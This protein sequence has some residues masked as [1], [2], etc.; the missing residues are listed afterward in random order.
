VGPGCS[1][2]PAGLRY[3]PVPGINLDS[4]WQARVGV[5][6]RQLAGLD[7]DAAFEVALDCARRES[8]LWLQRLDQRF[9]ERPEFA[10]F[11]GRVRSGPELD[12]TVPYNDPAILAYDFISAG[13]Y[14]PR[15]SQDS[16]RWFHRFLVEPGSAA[17]GHRGWLRVLDR[18]GRQLLAFALPYGRAVVLGPAPISAGRLELELPGAARVQVHAFRRAP[19]PVLRLLTDRSVASPAGRFWLPIEPVSVIDPEGSPPG[20]V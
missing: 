16:I 1:G 13:R 20:S 5:R 10:G 9:G 18:Q 15:E 4:R 19:E 3:G 6:T 14:P 17:R 8:T 2:P 7:A 11:W 12:W